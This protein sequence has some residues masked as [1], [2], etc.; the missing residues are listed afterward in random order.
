MIRTIVQTVAAAI[1]IAMIAFGYDFYQAFLL[2]CVS[3]WIGVTKDQ[4]KQPISASRGGFIVGILV[5]SFG[6]SIG[7]AAW[8]GPVGG[9]AVL[10]F[11]R[12]F[13]V[14]WIWTVFLDWRNL[15]RLKFATATPPQPD[16][17]DQRKGDSSGPRSEA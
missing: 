16:V 7:L 17:D 15:F 6:C 9:T 11:E 14:F 8:L 4:L 5:M 1:G 3:G 12:V 13:A 2:W 10:I